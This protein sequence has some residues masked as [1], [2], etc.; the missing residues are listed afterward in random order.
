MTSVTLCLYL[1][2]FL[3]LKCIFYHQNISITIDLS[4][5]FFYYPV[6]NKKRRRTPKACQQRFFFHQYQAVYLKP[7]PMIRLFL[8]LCKCFHQ[9]K[10]LSEIDI[11]AHMQE[12][13]RAELKAC[14]VCGAPADAFHK[15]GHYERDFICYESDAPV[16]HRITIFC[17][18]CS[19]CGHSHALEPSVIVPYS[20]YSIGFLLHV[21]YAKLTKHFPA[22]EAL[23]GHFGIS[24]S[25]YYRI[26]KRFLTDSFFLKQLTGISDVLYLWKCQTE[27]LH[28]VL[29]GYYRNCGRSFLQPCV[30]LR[31][32]IGL[33]DMPADIS[34]YIGN[35]TAT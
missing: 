20:S 26:Y 19:S 25:T 3:V 4:G 15:D 1:S 14:P 31:P 21:L 16:C 32:K 24:V 27:E 5:V 9:I 35:G 12:N 28:T 22:V 34:R 29:S 8:N 18:E 30:R 6:C 10:N 2:Y 23:C 33:K 13:L 17:V 7:I 11:L